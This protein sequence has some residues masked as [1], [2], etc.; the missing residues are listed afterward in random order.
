MPQGGR[1]RPQVPP[2][3]Q[4]FQRL[5][6]LAF[7]QPRKAVAQ[8]HREVQYDAGVAVAVRGAGLAD[9]AHHLVRGKIP[10]LGDRR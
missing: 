9:L 5:A 6:D 1:D 10:D 2:I 3:S 4:A 7:A 8:R